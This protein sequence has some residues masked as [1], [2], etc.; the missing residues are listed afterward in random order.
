VGS[1]YSSAA[2]DQF[3]DPS[4]PSGFKENTYLNQLDFNLNRGLSL[5]LNIPI[6]ARFQNNTNIALAKLN[7]E[8]SKY[9][10]S[11]TKNQLRQNIEQSYYNARAAAKTYAATSRQVEALQESFRNAEQRF[12]LGATNSVEYNQ[13]KN[14]FNR[15]NNDLIRNKYDYIFKLKVLDFYQGKPIQL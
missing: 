9:I 2:P 3:P 10:E 1:S 15:A 12:N 5:T 4:S 6:F 7:Y 8:N 14:D 11:T 13:I